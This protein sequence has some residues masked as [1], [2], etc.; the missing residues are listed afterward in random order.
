MFTKCSLKIENKKRQKTADRLRIKVEKFKKSYRI[1]V[2]HQISSI[3]GMGIFLSW[4]LKII[5][6]C[7]IEKYIYIYIENINIYITYIYNSYIYIARDLYH[8]IYTHTH[9]LKNAE[10]TLLFWMVFSSTP[11]HATTPRH[12]VR[13]AIAF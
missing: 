10:S 9:T 2:N 6:I 4:L 12:D 3:L 1:Q 5:P 13:S 7:I 8:P 11:R